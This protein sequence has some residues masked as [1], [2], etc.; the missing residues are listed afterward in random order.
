MLVL[1]PEDGILSLMASALHFRDDDGDQVSVILEPGSLSSAR[2]SSSKAADGSMQAIHPPA[3][4][5]LQL[6]VP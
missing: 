2:S 1:V 3:L 4:E 6:D 5:R